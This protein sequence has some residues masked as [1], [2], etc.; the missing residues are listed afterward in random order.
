MLGGIIYEEQVTICEFLPQACTL[1]NQG[2]YSCANRMP[3]PGVN[4]ITHA[5][6]RHICC[7]ICSVPSCVPTLGGVVFTQ[8]TDYSNAL[9]PRP[10]ILEGEYLSQRRW[11]GQGIH[12]PALSLIFSFLSSRIK[13]ICGW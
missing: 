1:R 7:G 8:Q 4:C 5:V 13:V 3:H 6:N 9:F 2:Q 12:G 10:D 11:H